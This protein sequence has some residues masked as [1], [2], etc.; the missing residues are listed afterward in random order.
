MFGSEHI[1]PGKEPVTDLL[2]SLPERQDD[3]YRLVYENLKSLARNRLRGERHDNQLQATSLVN[4]AYMKLMQHES[5][6]RD[7][8]HFF[9]VAG[10]A[11]RRILVDAARSRN[12]EKR[13]GKIT[14]QTL[15]GVEMAESEWDV[16]FLDL[17]EALTELERHSAEHVEIVRLHFFSGLTFQECADLLGISLSSVERR[18]R[19]ARAWLRSKISD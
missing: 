18:W 4:E 13:G 1:E 7:R 3:L 19:F 9:G 5:G 15:S 2:Q 17:D 12:R 10:E 14:Q 8:R 6:W 11:M 16:D